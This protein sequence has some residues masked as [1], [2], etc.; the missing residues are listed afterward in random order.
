[1]GRFCFWGDIVTSYSKCILFFA[2]SICTFSSQASTDDSV[3]QKACASSQPVLVYDSFSSQMGLRPVIDVNGDLIPE[4]SH[5][6]Y[7]AKIA[8][9]GGRRVVELNMVGEVELPAIESALFTIV[10]DIES[11]K[12]QY[13]RINFSQE[14]PLKIAS[15]KKDLFEADGS[16][17]EI[18]RENIA[19]YKD[20]IL[21]KLWTD[22]PDFRLQ[23]LFSIFSRLQSQG[24][25]VVVAAG[26]FGPSY[27]NL[28]SLFPGVISVGS[29]DLDGTKRLLSADNAL[30]T[31]WRKGSFV[32]QQL[33]DGVDINGDGA[34]D[35]PLESLSE[36]PKTVD[37]Y[38]GKIV[39]DVV[40]EI[41]E[42]FI[43]WT[44]KLSQ[45]QYVVPNAALNAIGVGLYRVS[46]LAMLPTVT[47]GTRQHF[48]KSG[49]YAY[50]SA[51]G[52]PTFFFDDD[53]D[54]KIIF[55]PLK[56]GT[57]NQITMVSGTSFAAPFICD[58]Y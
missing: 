45:S 38:R 43:A 19:Q 11:G 27:V 6:E 33:A 41:T 35:F 7:V 58:G 54:G 8:G 22:R 42:S 52:P 40:S 3:L 15:F 21:K 12:A 36:G 23:E 18:T 56:N 49:T 9:F 10:G 13:S 28:F 4:L 14:L 34:A 57:L 24:V 1:M 37:L 5:G 26:N 20:V 46:E 30:V 29:L 31:V 16:V 2:T 55:D 48:L 25:P 51:D 39:S 44:T 47:A 32:S 17:P 50:K 53:G